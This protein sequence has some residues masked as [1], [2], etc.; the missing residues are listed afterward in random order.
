MFSINWER[1]GYMV[2]KVSHYQPHTICLIWV[3]EYCDF[4]FERTLEGRHLLAIWHGASIHLFHLP[5]LLLRDRETERE[6]QRERGFIET[7]PEHQRDATQTYETHTHTQTHA[8]IHTHTHARTHMHAHTYTQTYIHIHMHK[9]TYKH[10]PKHTLLSCTHPPTK[11]YTKAPSNHECLCIGYA[12][13]HL[14][15]THTLC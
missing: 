11:A 6:R 2:L 14:H 7:V 15:T 10:T 5:L 1:V 9:H 4:I 3:V 13:K 12:H 8:Q